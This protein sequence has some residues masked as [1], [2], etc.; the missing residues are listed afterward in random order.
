M[1]NKLAIDWDES[2]LRLVAAQ[3]NG[4]HVKVTDAAVIPVENDNVVDTLRAAIQQ[5]GLEKTE[6]LVAIG[7][8]KAELRE[9]QLPPVPDDELPDMVRFQA[10]RN[11]ASS[12]DSSTVDFL[13]T[14]RSSEGV[15]MI[16]A[17]VGPSGLSEIRETCDAADLQ[18]KR[19]ALRPLAAAALLL[20][21]ERGAGQGDT[22]LIDLLANDAEIVVTRNGRVIFV[23]TVRMPADEKTRGKTLAGELRR[24]LVACGSRGSLDRVIL[25]GRE[26]VHADDRA[27]LATA[28]DSKVEVLDPFD[29]VEVNRQAK[30]R[31]PDHVGR[32][33]PLV[34]LLVADDGAAD[35]L[36][37]FLNPRQRPEE[38]TNQYRNAAMIGI[39]IAAAV[40][41]GFLMYRQLSNLDAEINDLAIANAN[42]QEQVDRAIDSIR[43]TETIDR[44]LDG[45]VNWLGEIQ[46]LAS[47]MPPSEEMIV[48]RVA[49][50][51]DDRGGGTM[52]IIGGVTEPEVIDSFEQSLRDESHRVVGDGAS[53]I[54]T[55]DDFEWRFT[56]SVTVDASAVRKARYRA[57][58]ALSNESTSTDPKQIKQPVDETP[59]V[60]PSSDQPSP[61]SSPTPEPPASE[62]EVQA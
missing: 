2:E 33:A 14:K 48:R 38:S 32:L 20:T 62:P 21:R 19:I 25:W 6:T 42:Q 8:G 23:R 27:M 36:V 49:G 50:S 18:I 5:R 13:V 29:L 44:Y 59:S 30:S 60:D 31:L 22:V 57:L 51:A 54:E 26:S 1:V 9:L 40:L 24:S 52:T 16:A 47:S 11:F 28:S 43:R 56:E 39:P 4:G 7:R 45:N 61:T 55:E 58:D 34:G 35:R 37:D 53:E 46:R 10:I 15:E 17:A 12:G 41:I 3:C